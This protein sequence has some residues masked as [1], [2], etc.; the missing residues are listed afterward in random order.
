MGNGYYHE[1][2]IIWGNRTFHK[3]NDGRFEC[4]LSYKRHNDKFLWMVANAKTNEE[5]PL[6]RHPCLIPTHP[7]AFP[8][9]RVCL[10]CDH[11]R[12]QEVDLLCGTKRPRP[13]E[14]FLKPPVSGATKSPLGFHPRHP[15]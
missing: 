10:L 11:P 8:G 5:E 3:D 12:C 13:S 6:G 7:G 15:M 9:T 1:V 14:R 4:S 2:D